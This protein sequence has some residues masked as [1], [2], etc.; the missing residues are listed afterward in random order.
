[1]RSAGCDGS[2]RSAVAAVSVGGQGT[3]LADFEAERRDQTAVPDEGHDPPAQV[4]DL[5]FGK[6]LPQLSEELL[7]G[8]SVIAGQ[9]LGVAD[10]HLFPS[11]KK[12]ALA[13]PR[14]LGD[15]LLRQPLLPCQ[16]KAGIQSEMA[17]VELRNLKTHEL[18]KLHVDS[19]ARLGDQRKIE[20]NERLEDLRRVREDAHELRPAKLSVVLAHNGLQLRID[21][22]KR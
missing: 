20:A 21:C 18:G 8:L 3:S 19:A 10:G 14:K 5:G 16:G 11:T 12:R 6:V 13:V 4:D 9:H 1:M 2:I 22:C 17:A 7:A 15:H